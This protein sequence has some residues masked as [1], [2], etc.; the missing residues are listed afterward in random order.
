MTLQEVDQMIV[1]WMI[2]GVTVAMLI[3]A[4]PALILFT[5]HRAAE[6]QKKADRGKLDAY[7]SA[8]KEKP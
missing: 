5:A 4:A 6:R 7:F 2:A 1:L 3:M 8:I